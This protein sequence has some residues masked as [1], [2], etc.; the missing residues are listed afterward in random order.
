MSLYRVRGTFW[1][2]RRFFFLVIAFTLGTIIFA[3]YNL[4]AFKQYIG[5]SFKDYSKYDTEKA[6][7]VLFIGNSHTYVFDLDKLLMEIS[8]SQKE[9]YYHIYSDRVA[10]GGMTIKSHWEDGEA[11]EAIKSK[12]WDYV[13]LQGQ[14]SMPL[15]LHSKTEFFEYSSKFAQEI[16]NI[17][18]KTIFYGTWPYKNNKLKNIYVTFLTSFNPESH[19]IAINQTYTKAAIENNASIVLT[20]PIRSSAPKNIELYDDSNHNS[21]AGSYLNALAFYKHIF[22]AK[23]FDKETFIPYGV[24]QEEGRKLIK[25]IEN[26]GNNNRNAIKK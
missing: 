10:S 9:Q 23:T 4:L 26:F 2:I 16:K 25:H 18:A 3:I 17:G 5:T 6:V 13:V 15:V 7:K 20:A 8:L 11:L 24:T 22:S 19:T 14:S 12:K 1:I 21:V